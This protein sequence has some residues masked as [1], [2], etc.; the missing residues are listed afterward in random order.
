MTMTGKNGFDVVVVGARCAGAAL[1]TFLARSGARVLVVDRDPLPSDQVLSTHTIHPPG[2]DILDELGVGGAVRSVTPASRIA[3]LRRGGAWADISF[4]NGRAELCPRRER[5]DGLL[6]DA[7]VR[8]GTELRD[9]TRVTRVLFE[10]GRAV[11]VRVEHAGGAD[12]VRAGLVVGAD[13]RRS[14]VASEVGAEEYMA[15]EGPRAMYW[16]YWNAPEKWHSD[17][18][19]FDMYLGHIGPDIRVV[20]QT[21]HG[22]LLVGSLPESRIARDWKHD[23]RGALRRNLSQD[24]VIGPLLGDADPDSKV[25]GTLKERYFF[26]RAV[27]PG[28]ALVG[29]AGHHKEFVIGDG[30]TEA[31]IQ[32]KSLARAISGSGDAALH[33][34]WRE[35]D[36]EA[37]PGYYWGRDEGSP[38][39][40]TELETL[41]FRKVGKNDR[42]KRMV[43][44][45]PEHQCSPYDAIPFATVLGAL[46]GALIRG[47]VR[48]AREFAAQGR[49]IAGYKKEMKERTA[50]LSE[51]L[52]PGSDRAVV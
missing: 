31:L 5:L 30:I 47:R 11:G 16:A 36:V 15:Y 10:D 4:S 51:T 2:V 28:W 52:S 38:G 44:Q 1:A 25:R 9:R 12:D 45:L 50:L 6:Q 7:A 37:L 20:F 3:R 19:P 42:L 22:Q 41:V 14:F 32:A 17:D 49:R 48:V 8:A 43:A 33:R 13:G 21:D 46:L 23:A 24:P 29:D 18:F 27:G 39:P 35:R 34:W 40:P 26:R